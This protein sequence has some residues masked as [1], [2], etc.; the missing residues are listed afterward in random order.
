MHR[1]QRFV[2]RSIQSHTLIA[3]YAVAIGSVLLVLG[4]RSLVQPVLGTRSQYIV[5]LLAV[6]VTAWYSGSIPALLALA[7]GAF[8]GNLFFSP[9]YLTFKLENLSDGVSVSFYMVIG[10]VIIYLFEVVK[11]NQT[12]LAD[13]IIKQSEAENALRQSEERFRLATE[14]L[15]GV[16]Y[17]WDAATDVAYRSPG[18]MEVLGYE[19][20]ES[21][22]NRKWWQSQ[23]HPDDFER[24]QQEHRKSVALH[25]PIHSVEY[26]VRH[27]DGHYLWVWDNSRII[28]NDQGQPIRLIGNTFSIDE[29]KRLAES[30]TETEER[31][32]AAFENASDA[33]V[34]SDEQG[35]VIAANQAYLQLYGFSAQEIIGHDYAIIYPETTREQS[36]TRYQQVFHDPREFPLTE[37]AV[38]R[39]DGTQRIVEARIGFVIQNEKRTHM[40]SVVRDLTERKQSERELYIRYQLTADLAHAVTV[41]DVGRITVEHLMKYLGA[42]V[43]NI[44]AYRPETNMFELLYVNTSPYRE[45]YDRWQ[46][47]PADE[48]YPMTDVVKRNRALWF[49]SAQEWFEAYPVMK[50]VSSPELG[51]SVHLPLVA[52]AA[53]FGALSLGFSEPRMF[54]DS[55][56]EVV[57]SMVFQCA[58]AIERARLADQASQLA[59]MHERQRLARDLHDNVSQLLFSSSVISEMLPRLW[60]TQPEKASKLADQL[61]TMVHGAMAE[62]RTLLWELR[63]ESII[64]TQLSN[65]LT[66]L[67]YAIRARQETEISVTVRTENEYILPPN[68]QVAFYRIAQ[69]SVHNV[70]K[71][72]HAAAISV[73][74]R[75]TDEYTALI[76]TD[77]GQGFDVNATGAG[78]GLRN[79]RER[80]ASIGA[81]F[82]VKSQIGKGTRM[83]LLWKQ[84]QTNSELYQLETKNPDATPEV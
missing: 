18:L 25:L 28:Y 4:F 14:A 24:V 32:R 37:S 12:K 2:I 29:R 50:D 47:F 56:K 21:T 22:N 30:L 74:L 63:P 64:Q 40:L 5:F 9:P 65:L 67:S 73:L 70:V 17:D 62:M 69:E 84:D 8:L 15:Q 53:T 33:M 10:I 61:N 13:Q 3:R 35:V 57:T 20:G 83:R 7:L 26:R 77:D 36:H 34:L 51:A 80:A 42:Q 1:I 71:H 39:K 38:Q 19:P 75:Q 23:I 41:E 16:I 54:T 59:V 81:Q 72:G 52:A 44:F 11:R 79:M 66:Q 31:F 27:K 76:I 78:F 46:Q 45:R 58:Q 43:G 49:Y 60:N 55:E 48:G 82:S 6:L 68:V